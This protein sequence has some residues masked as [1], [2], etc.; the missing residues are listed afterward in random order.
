MINDL[1]LS[2]DFLSRIQDLHSDYLFEI[3]PQILFVYNHW[4]QNTSVRQ[5]ITNDSEQF[6]VRF[7]SILD[8]GS[9][10]IHSI[11]H[12]YQQQLIEDSSSPLDITPFTKALINIFIFMCSLPN[13]DSFIDLLFDLKIIDTF[14]NVQIQMFI[15]MICSLSNILLLIQNHGLNMSNS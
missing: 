11:I 7:M 14:I 8:Y 2:L 15:E 6:S 5:S 10:I 1:C 4:I 12:D 9:N 3:H 13:S